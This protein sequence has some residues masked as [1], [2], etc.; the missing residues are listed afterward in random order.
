EIDGLE[1]RE[2]LNAV[3]ISGGV[4][5]NVIPDRCDVT[6]NYRFA[7]SKSREDAAAFIHD[8]FADAD[9]IEIEDVASGALPGL[10]APLASRFVDAVAK[11]PLA[12]KGWTDVSR[13]SALGIPAVNFGPGDPT[14]AHT[15]DERVPPAQIE[16]CADALRAWLSH[17]G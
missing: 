2:G 9:E 11:P 8:F 14:L 15:D 12:K 5:G 6:V 7:P 16:H 13:F 4:A 1:Y 3:R 10:E 17:A